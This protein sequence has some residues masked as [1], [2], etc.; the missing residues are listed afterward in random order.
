MRISVVVP[1]FNSAETIT[2]QLQALAR[3]QCDHWWEVI[4]ADNGSTDISR[5]V[6]RIYQSRMPQL[7]LI[8]ASDR[9]GA[10]HARNAGA[11]AALGNAL[12]F[13]DADDMVAP[14]WLAAMARALED[15]VFVA[16]RYDFARL[17][18]AR[19][20]KGRGNSQA[21]GLQ[22]LAFLP[23]GYAGGGSLG[24]RRD[25][26]VSVGGFDENIK[27]CED[28]DYCL[29]VQQ[30]GV[31]LT[32]VPDALVYC[33]H[34]STF[35][36]IYKQARNWAQFEELLFKKYQKPGVNE[37]WRWKAYC[38]E[39]VVYAARIPRLLSTPEGRVLCAWRIGRQMGF[40]RG[41][42]KYGVPPITGC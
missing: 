34:P 18:P 39:C 13:T 32:F 23:F 37:L 25:T 15:H 20:A 33:R 42:L 35:R 30:Q 38:L 2:E 3:Q 21:N 29:R 17:S 1:N 24:I 36:A 28:I 4:V 41:S 26:H 12:I 6:V 14:G 27:F 11:Q 19:V 16:C 9:R 8:D 10:S 31:S 7:R 5:D 40:L 22:H